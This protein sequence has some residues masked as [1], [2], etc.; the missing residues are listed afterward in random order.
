MGDQ[1]PD[2]DVSPRRAG[3]GSGRRRVSSGLGPSSRRRCHPAAAIIAALSVH[4]ARLGRKPCSPST[5]HASSRSSRSLELAATPPPRA[6][7]LRPDGRRGAA[8]LVDEDVDDRGLERRRDVG[9]VDLGVRPHVVHHGRLEPG[10]AEVEAVVAHRPAGTRSPS[11]RRRPRPARS[12]AHPGSRG[13]GTGRPCRTPRRR[14]R[15]SSGRAGGSARSRA[16]R[17]ASC[18]H[19]TR[20]ARR[21][22][23]SIVGS[24]SRAA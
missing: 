18:G 3:A 15:R 17:R 10:E 20:A 4:I 11:G 14:R 22:G 13:R 8:G 6:R 12:P 7:P 1:D 2:E 9:R 16:S 23:S 19:P 5:L 21:S 24:S